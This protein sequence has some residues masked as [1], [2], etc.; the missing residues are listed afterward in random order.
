[1]EI[2]TKNEKFERIAPKRIENFKLSADR[3]SKISNKVYFEFSDE[4]RKEILKEIENVYKFL[5]TKFS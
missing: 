1:M 2:E 3:L 4:Q 5:K